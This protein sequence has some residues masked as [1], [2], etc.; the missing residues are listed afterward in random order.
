MVITV[1]LNPVPIMAPIYKDKLSYVNVWM[2]NMTK[3][4][5]TLDYTF[6]RPSFI[7]MVDLWSFQTSFL[8]FIKILHIY[9]F[10]YCIW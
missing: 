6:M 1:S 8:L 2:P 10:V 9:L 5:L 4:L 3:L 7:V